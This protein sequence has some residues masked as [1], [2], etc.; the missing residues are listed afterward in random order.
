MRGPDGI[1]HGLRHGSA[2]TTLPISVAVFWASIGF[3]PGPATARSDIV[4]QADAL[5]VQAENASIGEILDALSAKFTLSYKLPPNLPR[6]MT[7]DYSGT[8]NQVLARILDGNDY[9]VEN[10][11][12]G[13]KVIVLGASAASN[14]PGSMLASVVAIQA[15]ASADQSVAPLAAGSRLRT[16][17]PGPNLPSSNPS[18][19]FAKPVPPLTSYLSK[20]GSPPASTP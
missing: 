5:E 19:P 20:N 13:I 14:S 2:A 3:A 1:V 18:L 4:G 16:P 12:D 11:E 6:S 15:P 10:S 9:V 8:L 7:G 17:L